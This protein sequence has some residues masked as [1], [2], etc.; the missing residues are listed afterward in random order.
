MLIV[1][2]VAGDKKIGKVAN[3]VIPIGSDAEQLVMC[4]KFYWLF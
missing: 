1:S 2:Q 4:E 3:I